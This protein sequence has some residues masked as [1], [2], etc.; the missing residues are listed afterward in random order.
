VAFQTDGKI[1]ISLHVFAF[2]LIVQDI[3]FIHDAA[4]F[5]LHV[6]AFAKVVDPFVRNMA[7]ITLIHFHYSVHLFCYIIHKTA[8]LFR[9]WSS[10]ATP[11]TPASY[12]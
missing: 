5:F 1:P 4:F 9:H 10:R 7:H 8:I 12:I 3:A 2:L 6:C 11:G